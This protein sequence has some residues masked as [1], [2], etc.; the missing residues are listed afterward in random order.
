MEAK[1]KIQIPIK[2][3]GNIVRQQEVEFL[4]NK[5]KYVYNVTPLLDLSD[6]RIANLPSELRFMV[7]NGK[8]Q[9]MHGPNDGNLHVLQ[10]IFQEMTR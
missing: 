10:D 6:R 8:V 9:S 1:V 4:V 5:D 7:D 3:A 2:G